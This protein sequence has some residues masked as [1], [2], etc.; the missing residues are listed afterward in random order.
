MVTMQMKDM[1]PVQRERLLER[2]RR[3]TRPSFYVQIGLVLALIAVPSSISVLSSDG[4]G[5]KDHD[6][7]DRGGG[8]RP[9]PRVHGHHFVRSRHV[10]RLGSVFGGPGLLPSGSAALVS[11]CP[12]R[13]GVVGDQYRS[14]FGDRLFLFAGEGHFFRHDDAGFIRIRLH[15]RH[16]V[17]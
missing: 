17:V 6:F 1:T 7:H 10:L 2:Q 13:I 15:T 8:L 14:G 9:D 16:P 5:R 11:S 4:C 12:G 3:F